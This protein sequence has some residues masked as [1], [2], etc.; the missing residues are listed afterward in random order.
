MVPKNSAIAEVSG[1]TNCVAIDSDFAGNLLFAGPGAGANA[2]ASAVMSDIGTI[3]H[4]YYGA[5]LLTLTNKLKPYTK[6]PAIQHLSA[7]YVRLA[8]HD[9]PGAMAAISSRMAEQNVSLESVVQRRSSKQICNCNNITDSQT[10]EGNYTHVVLVTHN[11]SE[12]A[13]MAAI[14]SIK[15]DGEVVYPPQ[16]IKIE[17]LV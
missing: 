4:G 11:T 13:M 7:Y 8:I 16:I 2:T 5:P 6:A 9:R 10:R 1:V 15:D 14:S 12:T 3:A 17:H